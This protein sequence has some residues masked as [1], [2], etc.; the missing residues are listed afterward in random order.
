[1]AA[2]T[3]ALFFT[4]AMFALREA[5]AGEEKERERGRGGGRCV[6][7]RK[8]RGNGGAEAGGTNVGR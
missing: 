6:Q 1:M 2:P 3:P 8:G 5:P 7:E 4:R